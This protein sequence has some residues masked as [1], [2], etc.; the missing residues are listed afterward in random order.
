MQ[1]SYT[2]QCLCGTVSFQIKASF[3]GFY[4]CHCKRCQKDT[5]SAHAANL[6]SM[7]GE[8]VWQSGLPNVKSFNL[9][10]TQHR[11]SFCA[12]CGSALPSVQMEGKMLVV[13]AGSL[14]GPVKVRPIAH[15]YCDDRADW[16][17]DLHLIPNVPRLPR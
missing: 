9:P 7:D 10:N 8:I 17:Q 12:H 4:L 13:P 11:K 1:K 5:G 15:I 14:D 2:G 16:D 6:F 3:T